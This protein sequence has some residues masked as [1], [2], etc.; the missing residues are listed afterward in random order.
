MQTFFPKELQPKC[1]QSLENL[2][3]TNGPMWSR[4]RVWVFEFLEKKVKFHSF[5]CSLIFF[6]WIMI[7]DSD[8]THAEIGKHV[9]AYVE[10]HRK[11]SCDWIN[12]SIELSIRRLSIFFFSCIFVISYEF[13]IYDS[14]YFELVELL[15]ISRIWIFASTAVNLAFDYCSI[16]NELFT[17]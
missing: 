4:L 13:K 17:E 11:M 8:K 14:Y 5:F 16:P 7:I 2:N 3:S 15:R 1:K 6:F 10:Y 9:S 12:Y